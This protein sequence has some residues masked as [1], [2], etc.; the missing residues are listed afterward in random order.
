M[1][2]A[3]SSIVC[4]KVLRK[5]GRSRRCYDDEC[6]VKSTC[7]KTSSG[8]KSLRALFLLL[9]GCTAYHSGRFVAPKKIRVGSS[10]FGN[11]ENSL[12]L[13]K[14]DYCDSLQDDLCKQKRSQRRVASTQHKINKKKRNKELRDHLNVQVKVSS[15]KYDTRKNR[16]RKEQ[17][18]G[19]RSLSTSRVAEIITGENTETLSTK[20]SLPP[21]LS[22]YENEEFDAYDFDES[23][24]VSEASSKSYRDEILAAQKLKRLEQAMSGICADIPSSSHTAASF[25]QNEIYDVLDSIRVSSQNNVNLIM[26]CADFLYLMLALEENDDTIG[27]S[28]TKSDKFV[29]KTLIMTREVLVAAAFHYCDCVRARK[30]GV[31]NVVRDLMEAGDSTMIEEKM[32]SGQPQQ[33]DNHMRDNFVWLLPA[34]NSASEDPNVE[35][36]NTAIVVTKKAVN[37]RGK[38]SIEKYG[39][40]TVRIAS[41][42][43]KLKRAEVMATTMNKKYDSTSFESTKARTRSKSINAETISTDASILRSFLLSVSEDWR[44]L[45]IRSA[46]CLYRLKGIVD[47]GGNSNFSHSSH[48]RLVYSSTSMQ[49]ARDALRVYAPLAQRMGMQ[50]LKSQIENTAFKILYPRQYDVSSA[51]HDR[52]FAEMQAIIQVLSSRIQH[53]LMSDEVFMA[54]IDNVSVSSRV[55]EP[56]SL[57]KK[58]LRYRKESINTSRANDTHH[59][60]EISKSTYTPTTLSTKWVPDAIALRVIICG[61]QLPME[62]EDSL[63]IREKM[64]CYFALQLIGDAWPPSQANIAKDY[65]KNPKPNG[66]QSLHYTATLEINGEEWPFEVQVC[67]LNLIRR[68]NSIFDLLAKN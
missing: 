25:T 53:L 26:G 15:N 6:S 5:A 67:I 21:W 49:T 54:N 50:R 29:P 8:C 31:Y 42:A 22:L 9:S 55:K 36:E 28:D 61:K 10:S 43:A 13:T 19:S 62:N 30:A 38:L 35:G 18:R 65:I 34:G 44:S 40:E 46:A 58:V 24:D 33:Q 37:R 2:G 60:R 11:L 3:T 68:M 4:L 48:K 1:V 52:D 59:R 63:R 17:H 45:V 39:E 57:W 51:L 56:Y 16:R 32:L 47:E 41:G 27:I 12:T 7:T 14:E 23:I 66:Y 64:L 20:Q